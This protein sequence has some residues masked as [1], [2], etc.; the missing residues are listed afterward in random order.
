MR[1]REVRVA[2]GQPRSSE[3]AA[4]RI[5]E[6][7]RRVLHLE[8]ES[9]A[10]LSERLDDSFVRVVRRI[11][12]VSGRVVVSGVGKSGL[13]ARRIAA[14]LASTGTPAHFLHP[15]EAI[16]GELGV[17]SGEDL[18][19][20]VSRS[21]ES[22]EL[23][24]LLSTVGRLEV[25]VVALTARPESSIGR[26]AALVLDLGAQEEACPYDLTPT[27]SSAAAVAMGDAL[28]MAVLDG[29]GSDA[30]EFVHLH[31]GGALGRR[32]RF[33]VRDVMLGPP[34]IPRLGPQEDLGRAMCEIAHRRGTVPVVGERGKVIGVITAGDLTRFA[35]RHPE[36]LRRPVREAMNPSPRVISPDA[37]AVEALREC[38]L[39]G[40]MAL[41]VVD[42]QA[43]LL[44]IVHLHDLLRAG[45][46]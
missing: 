7:A 29:R 33:R 37:L 39:H 23:G 42:E 16:H 15:V 24:E 25:P 41:P 36:F 26:A 20:V 31:P 4:D 22:R 12:A 44:G 10:A 35:E 21:G 17:L 11:L 1:E 19:I 5:L 28:A 6:T 38:E 9:V 13:V 34:E 3:L 30:E 45:L 14:I 32:L 18:L 40:I 43:Y 27:S 46:G 8:A 2:A